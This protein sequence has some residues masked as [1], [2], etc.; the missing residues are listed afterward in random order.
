MG[1]LNSD[2]KLKIMEFRTTGL[3]QIVEV[4]NK[5]EMTAEEKLALIE[6]AVSARRRLGTGKIHEGIAES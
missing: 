1:S 3:E 2:F 6:F 5:S 4:I